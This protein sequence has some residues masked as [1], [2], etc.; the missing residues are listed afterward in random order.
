M[1]VIIN[2]KHT[3]GD[4]TQMFD[5]VAVVKT[6]KLKDCKP[7]ELDATFIF[8]REFKMGDLQE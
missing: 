7:I 6:F 8:R 4:L 2:P 5:N 3:L 1:K